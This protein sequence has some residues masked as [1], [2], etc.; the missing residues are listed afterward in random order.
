MK[1]NQDNFNQRHQNNNFQFINQDNNMDIIN[2]DN[3]YINFKNLQKQ[4]NEKEISIRKLT[5][6]SEKA[7]NWN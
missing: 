6:D 4:L 2:Q 7:K 5:R 1:R 3:L